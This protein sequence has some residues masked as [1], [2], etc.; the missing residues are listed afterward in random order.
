MQFNNS[1]SFHPHI[2]V[3]FAAHGSGAKLRSRN[4]RT[5]K[6]VFENRNH[7]SAK[8][9]GTGDLRNRTHGRI[10]IADTTDPST[11]K[12]PTKRHKN[13]LQNTSCIKSII[14]TYF[15]S[16]NKSDNPTNSTQVLFCS[17]FCFCFLP[18]CHHAAR[19]YR[20][21]IRCC[22]TGRNT[23]NRGVDRENKSGIE[24]KNCAKN[25]VGC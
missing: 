10:Q 7:L 18:V 13:H 3:V 5:Q 25:S 17:F 15:Q 19:I 24:L 11:N 2:R 16:P 23:R 4:E 14:K 8:R 20:G 1:F 12:R 9:S 21:D 6:R 22:C